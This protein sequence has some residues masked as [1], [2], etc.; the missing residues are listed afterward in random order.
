MIGQH[1]ILKVGHCII[2]RFAE[3]EEQSIDAC[4]YFCDV[5]L[6]PDKEVVTMEMK[7]AA[8]SSHFI[9]LSLHRLLNHN[10][11]ARISLYKHSE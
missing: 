5:S 11:D 3:V 8:A 6:L 10:S 7:C 4:R 2:V 1:W 9:K